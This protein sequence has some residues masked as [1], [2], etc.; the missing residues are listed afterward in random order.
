[1]LQIGFSEGCNVVSRRTCFNIFRTKDIHDSK[2]EAIGV[3]YKRWME[4][5]QS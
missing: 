2:S 5:D 1:M 4:L 3:L